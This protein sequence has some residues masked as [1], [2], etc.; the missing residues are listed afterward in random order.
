MY[1]IS[2]TFKKRKPVGVYY[3]NVFRCENKTLEDITEIIANEFWFA[4]KNNSIEIW[5]WSGTWFNR[6][7]EK[8][9]ERN[10]VEVYDVSVFNS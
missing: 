6:I 8:L 4:L 10:D 3:C 7:K 5:H 9:K 1:L 2:Q